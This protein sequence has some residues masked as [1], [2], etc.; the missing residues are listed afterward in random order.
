MVSYYGALTSGESFDD[1]FGKNRPFGFSVG[2]GTV[3]QGWDEGLTLMNE[4]A[5][6]IFFIPPSLGY[7]EQGSPPLIEGNA[8]LI[9]YV[10]LEVVTKP[11][12]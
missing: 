10:D 7:G 1:S 6:Y 8:E 5:K 9:F 11:K 12:F 2:N 4:G 3:I